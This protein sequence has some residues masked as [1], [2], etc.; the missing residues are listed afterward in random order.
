MRRNLK[1]AIYR[2][3]FTIVGGEETFQNEAF[4]NRNLTFLKIFLIG[5]LEDA[6]SC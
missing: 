4:P 3:K 2:V 5:H 1:K 6:D